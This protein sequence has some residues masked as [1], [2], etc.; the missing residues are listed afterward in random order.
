MT[1]T[2][3]R[4]PASRVEGRS[5]VTGAARY[6]ADHRPPGR[7]HGVFV[8]SPVAAG[9]VDDVDAAGALAL[10]GVVGVL[11]HA[12]LPRLGEIG[13]P[14]AVLRLPMQ[15]D[16]V[17]HEGE[18]VALVLADTLEAAEAGAAAVRVR[19]DARP[20]VTPGHGRV[21][22]APQGGPLGDD[23]R[24][25][26]LRAGWEQADRRVSASYSQP[27]RHHNPMEP[28]ATTAAWDGDAV[29]VWDAVQHPHNVQVV[30]AAA[31]GL[32]PADVRV[33][34]RHTG[35]GFGG[36]G[37][38]W[39]HQVLVA[40]A[41]RVVGR[42]VSVAL[43]RS[44]MY[45]MGAYQGLIRQRVRVGAA[46]DGRLTALRHEVTTVTP[47]TDTFSEP[48]TEI[49]KNL[50]ACPAVHTEQRV[51]RVNLNLPN[52]MRAP[53]EGPGSWALESALD[54]LA[55]QLGLDPLD[56][57][58]VNRAEVDP[59]HGRPWSS[60]RLREAYREGAD[61]YGWYDRHDRPR[62]DG[63][64][65]I[66]HGMATATMGGFRFPGEVRVHLAPDGT[67]RVETATPDIGTG[68]PTV[69]T[70]LVGEEL[71]LPP[72]AV[73]VVWGDSALPRSGP[74]YGSSA[75]MGTGGA[76]VLACREIR[77]RLAEKTGVAVDALDV[78]AAVAGLDREVV[79][80][81]EF[82]LP[83]GAQFEAD[84]AGTPY[85]MRTWGAIFVEVGVDPGLG[86][87]RLRRAVGSYSAGRIVNP[88][89]ARSQ[90]IGSIVWGWGMA[91]LE[92][93]AVEPVHGR[94]LAKNLSGVAVPVNADIP[95]DI[96]VHFVE[97]FDGHASPTGA[98]GIGELGATGVAA[99]VANAVHDAVGVRI[100]ELPITPKAV[101]DALD[102]TAP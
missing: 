3:T 72:E 47:L 19:I 59:Q 94:F 38:V 52:P 24:R 87:L 91:A 83:G 86:L 98:R 96:D 13:P 89:T 22:P 101:L 92:Q 23:L 56:L 5:K 63:P 85:A 99:A 4:A 75:T 14:A 58:L 10:P 32:R 54:E 41:A 97:E 66:G 29:T 2:A 27:P 67:A 26:D 90:M 15:S 21:E 82:R 68:L 6:A 35:G 62:R 93:S 31:F 78:A 65:R 11:T 16:A 84:G 81:G 70:R 33:V 46:R 77:E 40:A 73:S 43:T 28:S 18:A 39:P 80:E 61:R 57:R 50:Y 71:G 7:L 9:R 51:E 64:W 48:A 1:E 60:N 88:V 95:A 55:P 53:V 49:S 45:S 36:K 17:E 37:F 102:G 12:D 69:L 44:Q 30:L 100:R 79:G 76:T 8:G 20:P 42:P 25:G 34:A 74:A